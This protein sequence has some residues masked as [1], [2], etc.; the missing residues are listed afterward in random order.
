MHPRD[1]RIRLLLPILAVALLVAIVGMATVLA[2]PPTLNGSLSANTVEVGK[3]VNQVLTLDGATSGT[4]KSIEITRPSGWGVPSIG[5]LR[6][7]DDGGTVTVVVA[8]SSTTGQKTTITINSPSAGLT[9]DNPADKLEIDFSI[10]AP[11]TPK[12]CGNSQFA[13]S[14]SDGTTSEAVSP[15][16]GGDCPDRLQ[17]QVH[18]GPVAEFEVNV[19]ASGGFAAN[20]ALADEN[21]PGI[22][23]T[24]QDA[25]GNTVDGA[26]GG[27]AYTGQITVTTNPSVS[28][29]VV[30][31]ASAGQA[32]ATIHP[33]SG[34]TVKVVA[35][36]KDDPSITGESPNV[37]VADPTLS[38]SEG[39]GAA[40]E[41]LTF[42]GT[43]DWGT[44]GWTILANTI[45]I[46]GGSTTHAPIVIDSVGGFPATTVTR[47]SKLPRGQYDVAVTV[48]DSSGTTQQYQ[49]TFVDALT[50]TPNLVEFT[51]AGGKLTGQAG[52]QAT[53]EATGLA[54][55]VTPAIL[56]RKE[57]GTDFPIQGTPP[58]TGPDGDFGGAQTVTLPALPAGT[59]DLVINDGQEFLFDLDLLVAPNI[60]QLDPPIS[61]GLIRTPANT[62]E[63]DGSAFP[64]D[65]QAG[66]V[67]VTIGGTDVDGD[68]YLTT[69]NYGEF[70]GH[71]NGP[72]QILTLTQQ[73]APGIHD[74]VVT[75][76]PSQIFTFTAAYRVPML[77]SGEPGS[78]VAN[79]T[80]TFNGQYFLPNQVISTVELGSGVG[81][82]FSPESSATIASGDTADA[83]GVLTLTVTIQGDLPAGKR[84]VKLVDDQGRTFYF[85]DAYEVVPTL[86]L[87]AP[88]QVPRG[89]ST[90]LNVSLEL[91][92]LEAGGTVVANTITIGGQPTVHGPGTISSN[93]QL[94]IQVQLQSLPAPGRHDLVVPVQN[95]PTYTFTNAFGVMDVTVE[96]ASGSGAAGTE[97][98]LSGVGFAPNANIS[99]NSIWVGSAPTTHAAQTV[100]ADG[101]FSGLQVT[102][103]GNLPAGPQD[104]QVLVG[105]PFDFDEEYTVSASAQL[106]PSYGDGRSEVEG[107][108]YG[109]GSAIT[110]LLGWGFDPG[111]T[112][113]A[114]TIQ[115]G[116]VPVTHTQV[117][118]NPDGTFVV[119][120]TLP[121]LDP[122]AK[123]LSFS[124]TVGSTT[125]NYS[126]PALF[127]VGEVSLVP[128]TR[129]FRQ[130]FTISGSH[131]VPNATVNQVFFISTSGTFYWLT[132]TGVVETDSD[133]N[134]SPTLIELSGGNLPAGS[135]ALYMVLEDDSNSSYFYLFPDIYTVGAAAKEVTV[136]PN[137]GDGR[138]GNVVTISVQNFPPNRTIPSNSITV[139]G[140]ATQHVAFKTDSSGNGWVEEVTLP[141]LTPGLKDIVVDGFTQSQAYGVATAR[142]VPNSS[143]GRGGE[144]VTVVGAHF[145]PTTVYNTWLVSPVGLAYLL[146]DTMTTNQ[147]EMSHYV[148]GGLPPMPMGVYTLTVTS[149][150]EF[151]FPGA[152]TVTPTLVA[153]PQRIRG[154]A[155]TQIALQ[156]WGFPSSVTVP[157][158]SITVDGQ[159][160]R[161]RSVT[162]QA[163]THGA[164]V[165]NVNGYF[166]TPVEITLPELQPGQY[167]VTVAGQT[168]ENVFTVIGPVTGTV[169]IDNGAA[170][171]TSRTVTLNLTRSDSVD[172]FAV[173]E[174]PGSL[175]GANIPWMPYPSDDQY[176]YQLTGGP[177]A[178]TVYVRFRNSATDTMSDVVSDD[179]V[180]IGAPAS[181]HLSAD[182]ESI[183]ADGTST[184]TITA[185]VLD[186]AGQPVPNVTVFFQT[187]LG[188]ITASATTGSDGQAIATLQA[189]TV[190]GDAQVQARSGD[191]TS[192]KV[193]QLVSPSAPTPTP[194]PAPASI[195]LSADPES[196]VADGT[197]TS[198][199]TAQV[200]DAAGQP[201][202]NVTVLFDSTRGSIPAS[203][204]TDNEGKATVTLRSSTVAGDA[205]VRAR[206][207]SLASD[208]QIVRFVAGPPARVEARSVADKL[209]ADGVSSTPVLITV[210]DLFGNP[211]PNVEVQ[212]STTLGTLVPS[213]NALTDERGQVEILLMA[214]TQSGTAVVTAKAGEAEGSATVELVAVGVRLFLPVVNR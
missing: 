24:A 87:I 81:S 192:S 80:A 204:I 124:A 129:A 41:A 34:G 183:V 23:I 16:S 50:I 39:T 4:V 6:F 147:G 20:V 77:T 102:L 10:T 56:L 118:V 149:D 26:N 11:T 164:F 122:G 96:P 178:V 193:I 38:V 99:A 86:R 185:Q 163:T 139:D 110:S 213:T 94:D 36:D 167:R 64:S 22:E 61:D 31:T 206:V 119:G 116:G 30:V 91:R 115:L 201:V 19:P 194:T 190:P 35:T 58:N 3:T 131:L 25:Y 161:G 69:D 158:N 152:F 203:A 184:S 49:K 197:S 17:V 198:T 93:G 13:I 84:T 165:V 7:T 142:V 146:G 145:A 12:T 148:W 136:S 143:N 104:V 95:G 138:A 133:G 209:P 134:L 54:A 157:E 162:A 121:G 76:N 14:V 90:P 210:E 154:E 144:K 42:A 70:F 151:V 111:A 156:G 43:G 174:N 140:Q 107:A 32:T 71:N 47:G 181:I 37:L 180:L 168:V 27:T 160:F 214:G 9:F 117:T 2:A 195:H 106:M 202:P 189:G 191:V 72:T 51:P 18:H 132:L 101:S 52:Q 28:A 170:N 176:I 155:G 45:T 92:G 130:K 29:P 113:Q 55:N 114:N 205:E 66:T 60:T 177:G 33:T 59:Y 128:V 108:T 112:I 79:E 103:G 199:I 196:I 1:A 150:V 172:Q 82:A 207:G 175:Q 44:A 109:V 153:T 53:L 5:T 57:D 137:R 169:S 171:T 78:G 46:D 8:S 188:R 208:V 141:A 67:S 159:T 65:L 88:A 62:T 105:T 48:K 120:L 68:Q 179:I 125:E 166:E 74:V 15:V 200:L 85:P 182:P 123:A 186:A 173:S 89:T 98:T 127:H 187:S 40:N 63:F 100:D 211:V 73:I 135:Y 83:N 75:I 97:L 212:L 21:R 126:F